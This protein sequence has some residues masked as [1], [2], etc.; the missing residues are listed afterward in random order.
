MFVFTIDD[1]VFTGGILVESEVFQRGVGDEGGEDEVGDDE[2]LGGLENH[3][4]W[5]GGW[6]GGREGNGLVG[7]SPAEGLILRDVLVEVEHG[8]DCG[9]FY[10]CSVEYHFA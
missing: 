7:G 4:C 5:G 1:G 3:R 2:Q 10:Y 8:V 9:D 6:E